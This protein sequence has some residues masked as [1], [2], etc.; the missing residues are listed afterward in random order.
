[1]AG[2]ASSASSAGHP[3]RGAPACHA[4]TLDPDHFMG[5]GHKPAYAAGAKRLPGTTATCSGSS[6]TKI[7][8][9]PW[10]ST[11]HRPSARPV[12][13]ALFPSVEIH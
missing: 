2:C 12:A 11:A 8:R 13:L 3:G 10:V 1:M 7:M 5:A 9:E 6:H 4:L